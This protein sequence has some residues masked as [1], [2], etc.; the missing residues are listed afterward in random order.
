[1]TAAIAT[2]W[3]GT[4]EYGVALEQQRAYRER[5]IHREEPEAIWL[6]EHPPVLTTGR[7]KVDDLPPKP[8]L[9]AHGIALF[10]TERG[11][12]ATYHGPGQIVG[13]VF[14]DAFERGLGVRGTV[15][16][17][18]AGVVA[19]LGELGIGGHGHPEHRGVFVGRDK[20]CALGLHF[21]KG[22]SMH[23]LALNLTTD[24]APYA[25]F[26]P[27]GITDGG[28]TSAEHLLGTLPVWAQS[29]EQASVSLAGHLIRALE[30]RWA[31]PDKR[32]R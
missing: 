31:A 23:G 14:V 21:R 29:P 16:A 13:Y 1:M 15:D 18:E 26:T 28:V 3:L 24:L 11:G 19:W 30:E 22:V 32:G 12:L 20:I 27:C 10:E 25:L 7:R 6:L 9:D 8:V 5:V 2:R 17:L 4:V